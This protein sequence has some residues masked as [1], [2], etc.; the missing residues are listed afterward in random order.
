MNANTTIHAQYTDA[1][2][3]SCV[4]CCAHDFAGSTRHCLNLI[5]R[6]LCRVGI[7]REFHGLGYGIAEDVTCEMVEKK[8]PLRGL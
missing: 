4:G 8:P 6:G 5:D 7:W 3:P 2:I 1:E